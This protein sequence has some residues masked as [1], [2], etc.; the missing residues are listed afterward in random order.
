[1]SF[2][3]L[4]NEQNVHGHFLEAAGV[5]PPHFLD[6]SLENGWNDPS[7]LISKGMIYI[8]ISFIVIHFTLQYHYSK[9]DL[10]C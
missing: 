1:M 3:P 5:R 2:L 6:D 4:E 7:V 8:Y 10:D 9:Q